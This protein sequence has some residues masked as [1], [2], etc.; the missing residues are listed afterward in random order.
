MKIKG[1]YPQ[2]KVVN[3]LIGGQFLSNMTDPSMQIPALDHNWSAGKGETYQVMV[4]IPI[5]KEKKKQGKK[6]RKEERK[7]LTNYCVLLKILQPL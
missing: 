5:R 6:S 2:D 7:K 4:D 1:S 3:M